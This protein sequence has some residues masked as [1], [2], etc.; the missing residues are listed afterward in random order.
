[1][2]GSSVR[3]IAA[4]GWNT[5]QYR[6]GQAEGLLPVVADRPCVVAVGGEGEPATSL[7]GGRGADGAGL[8]WQL[9][10]PRPAVAGESAELGLA[11]GEFCPAGRQGGASGLGQFVVPS[12]PSVR[13]EGRLGGKEAKPGR[14]GR[15]R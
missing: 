10:E 6:C 15:R 1:M 11:G 14:A 9:A 13:E 2:K 3:K 12:R 4:C 5:S 7:D 8:V